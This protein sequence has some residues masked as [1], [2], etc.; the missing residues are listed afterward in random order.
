MQ[1]RLSRCLIDGIKA[2]GA[3]RR[4]HSVVVNLPGQEQWEG[5]HY[6][7]SVTAFD[8]LCAANLVPEQQ[9][10]FKGELK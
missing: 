2:N 3:P 8:F 10:M 5:A 7:N 9:E 4:I 1:Y 6:K